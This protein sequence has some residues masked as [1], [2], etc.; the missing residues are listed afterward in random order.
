MSFFRLSSGCCES[1]AAASAAAAAAGAAPGRGAAGAPPRPAAT[2]PTAAP[3]PAAAPAARAAAS[4]SNVSSCQYVGL[5]RIKLQ[6]MDCMGQ[7]IRDSG[8]NSRPS[9]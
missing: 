8:S 7:S 3:A 9:L 5:M 1:F 2:A 4:P 6:N